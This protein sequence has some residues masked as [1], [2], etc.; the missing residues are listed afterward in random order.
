MSRCRTARGFTLVELLLVLAII[1]IVAA[2]TLPNLVRSIRGNR[3]RFAARSVVMAGRYA[4]SMAVMKQMEMA[5][6]LDLDGG[7]LSVASVEFGPPVEESASESLEEEADG[8]GIAASVAGAQAGTV[9]GGLKKTKPAAARPAVVKSVE[10]ARSLDQVSI[11]RVEVEGV[12]E[13]LFTK[14]TCSVVYRTNGTCTPYQ[15][16]LE[17]E[18]GARMTIRVDSLSSAEAEAQP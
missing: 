2:V 15:V 8:E 7:R 5:L 16:D 6:R 3:L 12:E 4:R 11:K 14:G 9:V 1:G 10:L 13:E 18:S 17:D